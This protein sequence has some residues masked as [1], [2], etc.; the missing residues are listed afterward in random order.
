MA[1]DF[2]WNPSITAAEEIAEL[3]G[4]RWSPSKDDFAAVPGGSVPVAPSFGH[5]L[6]A[7]LSAADGSIGR[8]NVFTHGDRSLIAF[9]GHIEK[10]SVSRADVFLD[11]NVPPDNLTAMDPVAMNNLNQP[12]VTFQ[13]PQPIRGK[14]DFTVSDVRKKFA[15]GSIMVF[16]ACH[17]SQDPA[18]LKASAQFFQIRVF[19][20]NDFIAYRPPAQTNPSRFLRAG[21][22]VAVGLSGTAPADFRD[23]IKDPGAV[24]ATP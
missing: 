17:S 1:G 14:K 18:F 9:S 20:F 13:A 24:S 16:Y 3:S 22:R 10:R 19:G 8:V 11:T 5:F 6:G 15:P 7:I 4:G 23:L 21:E 12:G 2:S